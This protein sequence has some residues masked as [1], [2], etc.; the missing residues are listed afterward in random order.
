MPDEDITQISLGRFRVGITGLKAAIEEFKSLRGRRDEE[1]SQALF[2]RLRPRNYIPASAQEEY[3]KAFLREF[4]KAMGEKV[5][6]DRSGLSIKILGPGCPSC[7]QLEQTVM[8]VLV[9]L[10]IPAEVDHVRDMKEIAALGV[11]GIPGLM[12]NDE[13]MTVGRVPTK[14]VLKKWLG[15]ASHQKK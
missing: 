7:E 11:F 10:D 13:V 4:K 14:A 6:E 5:V 3:K 1:I 8:A 15:E 2:E 9:E 12:I